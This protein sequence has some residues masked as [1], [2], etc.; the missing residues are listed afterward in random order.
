MPIYAPY[1]EIFARLNRGF[2]H[3]RSGAGDSKQN[4]R[5]RQA[6]ISY[7]RGS[8]AVLGSGVEVLGG[9]RVVGCD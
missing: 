3:K 7:Y 9:W 1:S 5:R 2:W 4:S 6:R 8:A